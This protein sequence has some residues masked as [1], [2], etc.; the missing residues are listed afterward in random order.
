MVRA[1]LESEGP[2][3]LVASRFSHD[4]H[5][6]ALGPTVLGSRRGRDHL[7]LLDRLGVQILSELAVEGIRGAHSIHQRHDVSVAGTV[8]IGVAR[9][10]HIRD[11]RGQRQHVLVVGPQHWQ[12]GDEFGGNGGADL[13]GFGVDHLLLALDANVLFELFAQRDVLHDGFPGENLQG[14]LDLLVARQAHPQSIAFS[15]RHRRHSEFTLGVGNA[16]ETHHP[17]S[18][19]FQGYRGPRKRASI[20]VHDDTLDGAGRRL[21]VDRQGKKQNQCGEECPQTRGRTIDHWNFLLPHRVEVDGSSCRC[22]NN[23]PPGGSPALIA[24]NIGNWNFTGTA[25]PCQFPIREIKPEGYSASKNSFP[26]I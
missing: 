6:T 4:V 20:L 13:R 16:P 12:S 22:K 18:L 14:E 21:R 11:S 10:V 7:D 1:H 26:Y 3:E 15:R 9:V 5:E 8:N 25:N 17:Y 23:P 2:F 19:V 24:K